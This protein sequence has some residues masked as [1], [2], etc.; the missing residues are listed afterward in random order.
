MP[1]AVQYIKDNHN[2]LLSSTNSFHA[3]QNKDTI[4]QIRT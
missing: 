4:I 3:K 1:E 2:E